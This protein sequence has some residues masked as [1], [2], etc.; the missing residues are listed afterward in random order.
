MN[1]TV[2]LNFALR[3]FQRSNPLLEL[4]D[5]AS[6]IAGLLVNYTSTVKLNKYRHNLYVQQFR[7]MEGYLSQSSPYQY[8]GQKM[9]RRF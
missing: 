5:R 8:R 4:L 6:A 7:R 2:Y 1:P 9:D 3:F